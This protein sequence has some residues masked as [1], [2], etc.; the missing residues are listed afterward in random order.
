[1]GMP[2]TNT[3]F[4]PRVWALV[5]GAV[6]LALAIVAFDPYLFT[7]GDN[8]QYYALTHALGGARRVGRRGSASSFRARGTP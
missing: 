5:G 3:S 7:G 8:A 1:M 4:R 6:A 2:K